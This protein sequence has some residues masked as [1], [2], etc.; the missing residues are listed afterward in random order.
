MRT[1]NTITSKR[2]TRIQARRVIVLVVSMT[3]ALGK[4]SVY[5]IQTP[6]PCGGNGVFNTGSMGHGNFRPWDTTVPVFT[7]MFLSYI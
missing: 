3:R 6:I 5:R 7:Y 2:I 1:I 4:Q